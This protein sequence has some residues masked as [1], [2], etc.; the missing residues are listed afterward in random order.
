[1]AGKRYALLGVDVGTTSVK[2][3]AFDR[4]GHAVAQGVRHITGGT[5]EDAET[6]PMEWPVEWLWRRVA[7]AIGD[8]LAALPPGFQILGLAISSMGCLGAPFDAKMQALRPV[9]S[10]YDRRAASVVRAVVRSR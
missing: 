10:S 6:L 5:S 3:L 1:M 8:A 7:G 4:H 2:A 9:I